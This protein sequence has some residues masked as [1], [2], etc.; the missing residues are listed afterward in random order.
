MFNINSANLILRGNYLIILYPF[1]TQARH[2]ALCDNTHS[3]LYQ[4]CVFP[5]RI[6]KLT[7]LDT[8]FRVCVYTNVSA[9]F[10]KTS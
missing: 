8:G 4:L 2:N 7:R 6:P 9:K 1:V 5:I 3:K 10:S